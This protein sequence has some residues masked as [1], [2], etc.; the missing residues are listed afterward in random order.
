VF[1]IGKDARAAVK[2]AVMC[3]DVA[4]SVHLSRQLGEPLPIAQIDIDRLY[5]RYQN[6]YGQPG[7]S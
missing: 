4:R 7:N 3:E 1:T 5:D 2:A 6:V